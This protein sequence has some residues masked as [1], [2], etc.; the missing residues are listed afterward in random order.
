MV[1]YS[2]CCL[3]AVL[4]DLC[5]CDADLDSPTSN[6]V[7]Q[8]FTHLSTL[9]RCALARRPVSFEDVDRS[10]ASI[11]KH[12]SLQETKGLGWTGEAFLTILRFLGRREE[13]GWV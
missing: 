3:K 7:L 13:A 9:Y 12:V 11:G 5:Y 1:Y 2:L 10:L 8:K 6:D 4:S